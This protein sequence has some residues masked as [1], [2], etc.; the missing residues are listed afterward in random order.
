MAGMIILP[1]LHLYV[2][3][4]DFTSRTLTHIR[5]QPFCLTLNAM[6]IWWI[7]YAFNPVNTNPE[8]AI[9]V[10]LSAA[11]VL[12]GGEYIFLLSIAIPK[13][14]ALFF[15][16]RIFSNTSRTFKIL[17]WVVGGL[18]LAWLIAGIL[19]A[20]F[21]CSPT[22]KAFEPEIPGQCFSQ[23][24]WFFWTALTEMIIDIFI[25]V[26]PLPRLWQLRM[27]GKKKAVVILTFLGAYR[28]VSFSSTSQNSSY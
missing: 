20:I 11:K 10:L 7:L 22:R 5:P 1:L 8:K 2:L 25:L 21:Q 18:N 28:F 27:D 26:L 9:L 13:F 3:P 12:F 16:D 15:Y 23:W 19:A 4:E 24:A 17:L 14:S 6:L